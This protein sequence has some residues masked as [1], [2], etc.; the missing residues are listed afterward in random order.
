MTIIKMTNSWPLESCIEIILVVLFTITHTIALAG[1]PTLALTVKRQSM[2]VQAR[3]VKT[4]AY[5]TTTESGRTLAF[6]PLLTL[7]NNAK[8]IPYFPILTA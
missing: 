5:V 1:A 6:A 3:L 2:R 4:A 7:A 8:R